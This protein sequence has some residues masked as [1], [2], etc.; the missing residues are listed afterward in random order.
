MTR[1]NID[2]PLSDDGRNKL[3]SMF[4]ELYNKYISSG[5]D[6]SEAKIKAVQALANSE[7]T[8]KE[9]TQAILAGDSSPLGGQ[10][11]V[12]S[13]GTI[14]DGPQERLIAENQKLTSEL[15]KKALK[16]DVDTLTTNKADKT[17]VDTQFANIVDGSPKG[18]YA[19]L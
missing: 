5:A 14:H 9:L 4:E 15:A 19:T 6:S 3:N 12:G 10:L 16:T 8:Q 1:Y 17:Y 13:D 11:S 7:Q 2:N 18:T